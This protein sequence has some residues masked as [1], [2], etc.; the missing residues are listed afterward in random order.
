MTSK[1]KIYFDKVQ[2]YIKLYTPNCNKDDKYLLLSL[3][4][5]ILKIF[6]DIFPNIE[7]FENYRKEIGL[8]EN[9]KFVW[10]NAIQYAYENKY[11]TKEV[12]NEKYIKD[13]KYII[14]KEGKL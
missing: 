1:E 13:I 14:K 3:R 6:L 9:Y 10:N 11:I 4:N 8:E 2:N 5:E 7:T 12:Y